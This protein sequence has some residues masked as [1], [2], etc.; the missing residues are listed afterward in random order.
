MLAAYA[1][2]IDPDDPLAGLR[3]GE[4][5]EPYLFGFWFLRQLEPP[6]PAD[7]VYFVHQ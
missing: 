7:H 6:L 3:V 2:A 1:K 5:P 4:R